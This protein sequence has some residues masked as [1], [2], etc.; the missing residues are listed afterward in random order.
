MLTCHLC[1]FRSYE[2]GRFM[3]HLSVLHKLEIANSFVCPVADCDR[4]YQNSN[5]LKRHLRNHHNSGNRENQRQANF[6]LQVPD[7]Y[8]KENNENYNSDINSDDYNSD[9]NEINFEDF[10][11]LERPDVK[12]TLLEK[13]ACFASFFYNE[14]AMHRKHVQTIVKK[15]NSYVNDLINNSLKTEVMNILNRENDIR[16]RIK[17]T[18][19]IFK[20]FENP[21][22]GLFSEDERIEHF[23]KR[24][25]Y[26][27]PKSYII[28][29][30][31][32]GKKRIPSTE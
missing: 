26:F 8:N 16:T 25:T 30:D 27:E 17:D 11:H 9:I 21:L 13:S 28:D 18:L 19:A 22:N 14:N 24:E 10:D 4:F 23:K 20:A 7:V 5:L 1:D 6:Q 31:K 29:Q 12:T 2:F 3:R 15:T 32:R